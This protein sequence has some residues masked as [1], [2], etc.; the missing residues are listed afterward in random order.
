MQKPENR[1]II[2]R[3]NHICF[4]KQLAP[5][6][7]RN[8]NELYPNFDENGNLS[9]DEFQFFTQKKEDKASKYNFY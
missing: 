3:F 1:V 9:H 4:E 6:Q 2:G 8:K 5:R 7:N